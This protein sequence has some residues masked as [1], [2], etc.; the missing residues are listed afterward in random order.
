MLLAIV[1]SIG[2]DEGDGFEEIGKQLSLFLV[3]KFEF[4]GIDVSFV[5]EEVVPFLILQIPHYVIV[6][7]A[8]SEPRFE[9]R[10]HDRLHLL[11]CIP[12]LLRA[13]L[14]RLLPFQVVHELA[15]QRTVVIPAI[16]QAFEASYAEDV[17]AM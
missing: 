13:T 6:V 7:V 16:L 1:L 12:P 14:R 11:H 5:L 4:A 10:L 9:L 15:T 8:N 2:Y 17:T 3:D